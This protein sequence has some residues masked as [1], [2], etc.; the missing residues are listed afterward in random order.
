MLDLIVVTVT[1]NSGPV[2]DAWAA[3][4]APAADRLGSWHVVVADNASSDDSVARMRR[5]L[6]AATVVA[7]GRNGGYAAGINAALAAAPGAGVGPPARY[8][9]VSNPDVRLR[10]D[11]LERLREALDRPGVGVAVPRLVDGEGRLLLTRHRRPTLLRAWAGS[12]LGVERAGRLT[13][14]GEVESEPASYARSGP[15]DWGS[16]AALLVR[17]ECLVDT[18]PWDERFFLYSEE[19]EW[20]LRA[21]DR[22]WRTW[23]VADAEAVHVGGESRT[24]PS[25]WALLCVNRV[26]LYAGRTNPF[27]ALLFWAAVVAGETLR[28]SRGSATSRAALRALT[29]PGTWRGAAAPATGGR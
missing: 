11:T 17:G 6:P 7:T 28:A 19:T 10:S 16:G 21:R 3:S 8:V 29:T 24:S 26:R 5:L 22:G 27:A 23:F 12:L 4:L 18:G 9:L 14:L 15:V 13:R 1:Y 20:L 25:L 2:L